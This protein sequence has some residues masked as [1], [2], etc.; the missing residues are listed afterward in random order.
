L[1][2]RTLALEYLG[3]YT[4]L[5]ELTLMVGRT[6]LVWFLVDGEP[7]TDHT[8]RGMALRLLTACNWLQRRMYGIMR[9]HK[10][11]KELVA[12]SKAIQWL[13]DGLDEPERAKEYFRQFYSQNKLDIERGLRVINGARSAHAMIHGTPEQ[14]KKRWAEYQT[15]VDQCRAD[16][17][18]WGIT[19]IQSKV[20]EN[21]DC[22]LKTIQRHTIK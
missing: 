16:N 6:G 9:P 7:Y 12:V 11:D 19:A 22:S 20:A 14:K 2:L 10:T 18:A 5:P 15:A 21:F 3:D 17:P 4:D 13:E 8:Q 1:R